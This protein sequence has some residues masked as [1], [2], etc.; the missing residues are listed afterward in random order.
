[1]IP[2]LLGIF[3]STGG[4][5]EAGLVAKLERGEDEVR[6]ST[7]EDGLDAISEF[8]GRKYRTKGA[9]K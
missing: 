9:Y 2:I 3:T 6:V 4:G 7:S 5:E 1:M 8:R